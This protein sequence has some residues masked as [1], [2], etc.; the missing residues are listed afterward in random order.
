MKR[1][2]LAITIAIISGS[3]IGSY[4]FNEYNPYT[5]HS[6]KINEFNSPFPLGTEY[7]KNHLSTPF[8]NKTSI[9]PENSNRNYIRKDVFFGNK[10]SMPMQKDNVKIIFKKQ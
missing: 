9:Y 5:S 8:I 7:K 10:Y 1:F 2:I 6:Q 4:L 3:L